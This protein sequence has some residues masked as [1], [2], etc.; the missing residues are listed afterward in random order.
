MSKDLVAIKLIGVSNDDSPMSILYVY[1]DGSELDLAWQA[2]ECPNE[3]FK[4]IAEVI[5]RAGVTADDTGLP[6]IVED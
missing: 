3:E 4:L 1:E 2:P 6:L 5:A